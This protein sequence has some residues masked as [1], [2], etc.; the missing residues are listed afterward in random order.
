MIKI[1]MMGSPIFYAYDKTY[2]QPG[3]TGA[4]QWNG[5]TKCFEVSNGS[6]WTRIDNSIDIT[7]DSTLG[8]MIN[9]F[10]DKRQKENELK[11]LAKEHPTIQSLLSDIEEKQKQLEMVQILLKEQSGAS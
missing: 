5:L 2:Q 7:V 10:Q 1:N 8:E 4:V 3:I 6:S 11:R 9:W